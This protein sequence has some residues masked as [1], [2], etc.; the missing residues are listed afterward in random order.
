MGPHRLGKPQEPRCRQNCCDGEDLVARGSICEANLGSALQDFRFGIG[1]QQSLERQ[2]CGVRQLSFSC[3]DDLKLAGWD[4]E[5]VPRYANYWEE[6]R[7]YR[8]S[9][10]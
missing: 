10:T 7:G 5:S 9:M 1:A 2:L 6:Y 8:Y 3:W 4:L